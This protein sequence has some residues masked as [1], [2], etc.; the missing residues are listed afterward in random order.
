[1]KR[2][3]QLKRQPTKER[4][5]EYMQNHPNVESG[6]IAKALE[7]SLQSVYSAKHTL[8]KEMTT[9]KKPKSK[10]VH[11]M[12]VRENITVQLSTDSLHI[13]SDKYSLTINFSS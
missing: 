7:I 11:N 3:A 8:K 12:T 13:T 6:E 4:V 9:V 1:M 2:R 5:R 10:T